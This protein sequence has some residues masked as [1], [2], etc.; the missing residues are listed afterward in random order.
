M[1]HS[2]FLNS[3]VEFLISKLG[4][5]MNDNSILA[6]LKSINNNVKYLL[7]GVLIFQ[8]GFF[9]QAY[10]IVYM[11]SK[12]F[13]SSQA[14]WSLALLCGASIVGAIAGSNISS[15][16]GCKAN[17]VLASAGLAF[18][19]AIIPYLV[20]P[21]HSALLWIPVICLAGFFS[22]M[23]RPSA[24]VLLSENLTADV[25]I[26]GFSLFRIALNLGG[27]LG[28]L[29]ATWLAGY[30]WKFVFFLNCACA[31]ALAAIVLIFIKEDKRND[32]NKKTE[33]NSLGWRTVI[34]DTKYWYFLLAMFLS[35]VAYI[36]IYSTVP[37]ALESE[38]HPLESYSKV[39]IT[40]S[41]VL[42]LFELQISS[43]VRKLP[44]W[45]PA[46]FGTFILCVGIATFGITINFGNLVLLS[47]IIMVSGLMVSGPT[48]FAYPATFPLSVRSKYIAANQIS[49]TVGNAIGP[50][51]GLYFYSVNHQLIW[52]CCFAIAIICC[53]LLYVGMKPDTKIAYENVQ[54]TDPKEKSA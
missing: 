34:S 4:L 12:G 42:I 25:Q 15:R 8:F 45:I 32:V 38:N 7:L 14:S 27:A 48:M 31:L 13:T 46:L 29:V 36:Q 35:S 17:I 20:S 39:L 2:V 3:K 21:S 41:V 23:Y 1:I 10:I 16:Y 52:W 11:L 50:V 28:P 6:F 33:A 5:N 26:M 51:I 43:L 40:Y 54:D 9:L 53:G 47:A 30:D 24:S 18:S 44:S 37:V 49:F 22:Q 19:V